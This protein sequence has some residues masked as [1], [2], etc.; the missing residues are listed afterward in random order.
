M[1]PSRRPKLARSAASLVI[2]ASFRA[3]A[4]LSRWPR[5][6]DEPVLHRRHQILGRQVGGLDQDAE[7]EVGLGTQLQDRLQRDEVIVGERAERLLDGFGIALVGGRLQAEREREGGIVRHRRELLGELLVRVAQIADQ[8][9]ARRADRLALGDGA[10]EPVEDVRHAAGG[11]LELRRIGGGERRH[12]VVELAARRIEHGER[13]RTIVGA[14]GGE[15]RLRGG[16]HVGRRLPDVGGARHVLQARSGDELERMPEPVVGDERR[17][18]RQHRGG[19]D[20]AECCEQAAA[21]PEAAPGRHRFLRAVVCSRR[22]GPT[23]AGRG[24]PRA[25]P[26]FAQD[27]GFSRCVTALKLPSGWITVR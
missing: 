5:G 9:T 26:S 6:R 25:G 2:C 17:A 13:T 18:A 21:Q 4:A 7:H 1:L 8:R 23:P 3:A 19:G 20:R 24:R 11:L 10:G 14:R 22:H 16:D 12:G 27:F 15:Q